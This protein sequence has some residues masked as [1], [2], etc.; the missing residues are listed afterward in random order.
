MGCDQFV[1]DRAETK[2][3]SCQLFLGA[4]AWTRHGVWFRR[5]FYHGLRLSSVPTIQT[6]ESLATTASI[7][8][9]AFDGCR[10]RLTNSCAHV[11]P[12]FFADGDTGGHDPTSVGDH[13]CHDDHQDSATRKEA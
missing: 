4:G 7:L 8:R 12:T 6:H 10:D 11:V 2:L 9:V 13:F 1:H 5:V 3:L